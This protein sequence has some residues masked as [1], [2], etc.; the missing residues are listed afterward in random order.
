MVVALSHAGKKGLLPENTQNFF[1]ILLIPEPFLGVDPDTWLTNP[2]YMQ[3]ENVVNV[4]DDTAGHGVT[5]VHECNALLAKDEE[6]THFALQ[7]VKEHRERIP[8]LQDDDSP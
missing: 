6:R 7:V 8:R 3:A 1:R 5:M 2:D 4:I